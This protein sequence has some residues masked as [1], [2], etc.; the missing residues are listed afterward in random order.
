MKKALPVILLVMV[1]CTN[2]CKAK[3]SIAKTP[4]PAVITKVEPVIETPKAE[5]KP[6]PKIEP[7]VGVSFSPNPVKETVMLSFH[8]SNAAKGLVKIFD[9]LGNE[10]HNSIMDVREGMNSIGVSME[11]LKSGIYVIEAYSG[12]KKLG[13]KRITKE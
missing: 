3:K 4:E 2:G 1:I 6:A 10:V 13:I 12:S 8:S 5:I 7:P 11:K 9:L